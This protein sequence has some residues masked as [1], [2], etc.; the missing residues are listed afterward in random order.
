M[1]EINNYCK[2]SSPN[3]VDE[4]NKRVFQRIMATG[5]TDVLL[6]SRPQQTLFT[7]PLQNIIPHPPCLS[8]EL[9]FKTNSANPTT[10]LGA[11]SRY[12]ANINTESELRNQIYALQNS[13]Q[14]VYVPNS[15]SDLYKPN[16]T[17]EENNS[18]KS[19][20][21]IHNITPLPTSSIE[22]QQNYNSLPTVP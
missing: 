13:P 16:T 9:K 4:I 7:K 21:I 19:S 8:Q 14:S 20:N 10:R 5:T 12:T 18:Y 1:S 2:S 11:W 22:N 15:N 3:T 17:F 6:S